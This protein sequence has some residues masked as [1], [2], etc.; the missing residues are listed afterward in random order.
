MV[1]D[2]VSSEGIWLEALQA[3]SSVDTLL[4]G[5]QEERI[6]RIAGED[7]YLMPAV[8]EIRRTAY[9]A[10]N[11]LGNTGN[12]LERKDTLSVMHG[13]ESLTDSC[14]QLSAEERT[15]KRVQQLR[16]LVF[17][18]LA[19]QDRG[20]AYAAGPLLAQDELF[21]ADDFERINQTLSGFSLPG[22]IEVY[23]QFGALYKE[24]FEQQAQPVIDSLASLQYAPLNRSLAEAGWQVDVPEDQG[25]HFRTP[26]WDRLWELGEQP[27][28]MLRTEKGNI[29]IQLDP[30]KAPATISAIDR[31]SRAGAYSGVPFHR[32]VPNFVIQGGDVERQDGFGG[33]GFMLPTEPTE[34]EFVRGAS[35]IASA[36][37][38]TE[39]SQYFIMHQWSPHL[40]GNYTRF[41]KVL[42]GMDVVDQMEVGGVVLSPTWY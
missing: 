11:Y 30:L 2:T 7:P 25:A 42:E 34:Q 17:G 22:D 8:L 13:L 10:D 37:T 19:L 9:S 3:A 6:E 4:G 14:D 39:G 15:Q 5:E 16:Q 1:P 28:W 23:Q 33:P 20:V 12:M 32:I 26:D 38:D 29:V 18:A 36:W 24:R 27:R 41:G 21:Q 35:G 31:L 40:N